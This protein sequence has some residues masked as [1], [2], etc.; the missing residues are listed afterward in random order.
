MEG[1]GKGNKWQH[2]IFDMSPV[3][4]APFAGRIA[5]GMSHLAGRLEAKTMNEDILR[6]A[7]FGKQVDLIR[8]GQCPL[9][10]KKV[11]AGNLRDDLSRREFKISGLCQKC[12][13]E[14]FDA[15]RERPE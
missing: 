4:P 15:W 3:P 10:E 6:L 5:G 1:P 11:D 13:D 12:Q 9:C 7:G 14:T 8:A 2:H